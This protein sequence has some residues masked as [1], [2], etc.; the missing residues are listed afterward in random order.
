MSYLWIILTGPIIVACQWNTETNKGVFESLTSVQTYIINGSK[1]LARKQCLQ[2][3]PTGPAEQWAGGSRC[4]SLNSCNKAKI[5]KVNCF[6]SKT[7]IIIHEDTNYL[8]Q[9]HFRQFYSKYQTVNVLLLI[10]RRGWQAWNSF[11]R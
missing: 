8:L 6:S 11:V 10:S 1:I 7:I 9:N 5:L 4:R 3:S 2:S